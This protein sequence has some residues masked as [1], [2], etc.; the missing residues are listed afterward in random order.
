[1]PKRNAKGRFVK[2][3]GKSRKRKTV[4]LTVHRSAPPARRRSTSIARR[5]SGAVA[6]RRSSSK[7]SIASMFHQPLTYVGSPRVDDLIASVTLGALVDKDGKTRDAAENY[8]LKKAP[9]FLRGLGKHGVLA[10]TL[11]LASRFFPQAR[12]YLAPLAR[13]ETYV[14]A[15]MLASRGRFY[16]ESEYDASLSGDDDDSTD[17]YWDEAEAAGVEDEFDNA[18]GDDS[19]DGDDNAYPDD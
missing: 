15:R 3:S 4:A 13:Q 8:I 16:Q 14:A 9:G 6:R 2:G 1:M 5:S 18:S 10:L 12:K 19:A 7:N 17:G 11:G